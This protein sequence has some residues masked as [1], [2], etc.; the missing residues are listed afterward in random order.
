MTRGFLGQSCSPY[1]SKFWGDSST[2]PMRQQD[3]EAAAKIHQIESVS[4]SRGANNSSTSG[5]SWYFIFQKRALCWR[6]SVYGCPPR[7]FFTPCV[8]WGQRVICQRRSHHF[9][10]KIQLRQSSHLE[11]LKH[12]HDIFIHSAERFDLIV[13][14]YSPQSNPFTWIFSKNIV[15]KEV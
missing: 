6:S 2:R 10:T 7:P 13:F 5:F 11:M 1:C 14:H 9:L 15:S 8:A 12:A 4:G 3:A